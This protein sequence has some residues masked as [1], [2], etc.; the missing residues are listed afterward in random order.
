M[1]ATLYF[2]AYTLWA[3]GIISGILLVLHYITE[4]FSC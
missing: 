3:V 1:M 2:L 4:K